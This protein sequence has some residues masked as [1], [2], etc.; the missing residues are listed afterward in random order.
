MIKNYIKIRKLTDFQK[1]LESPIYLERETAESINNIL[2][3]SWGIQIS[4]NL[5]KELDIKDLSRF[6]SDLI[7]YRTQQLCEMNLGINATLYIWFEEEE[8]QICFNV[9]SGENIKLPFYC[10]INFVDSFSH[11]L[12]DFLNKAHEKIVYGS[13]YVMEPAEKVYPAIDSDE[14]PDVSQVILNVWVT[15]LKCDNQK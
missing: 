8:L 4:D 9:L 14:W 1:I 15:T 13:F 7:K 11:I 10:T 3:N 12:N 5:I 6:I 2:R